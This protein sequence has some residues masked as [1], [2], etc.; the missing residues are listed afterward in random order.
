M[1]QV[2]KK[3]L[4]TIA[5]AGGMFAAAGGHAYADSGAQGHAA[6]SPGVLAGNT[7]QL[8]MDVPVQA[9]GNTVNVVGLLNP[10]AGNRCVTGAGGAH[11]HHQGG[12]QHGSAQTQGAAAGSP[13]VAAGNAVQMPVDVPV[14]ICGNSVSVVGLAN[15]AMGNTCTEDSTV[16]PSAGTDH[17]RQPSEDPTAPAPA[18]P[19]D[20]S[21]HGSVAHG[22]AAH[23]STA[24][25]P[26]AH[27]PG[28]PR[29]GQPAA[30][31]PGQGPRTPMAQPHGGHAQIGTPPG[32]QGAADGELAQTGAGPIG[33]AAPAGAALLLGGAVL[34]RRSRSARR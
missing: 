1:R 29:S 24:H 15:P 5:A 7:V 4:L 20:S 6:N 10:A 21:T 18:K 19:R 28:D 31:Y 17:P 12:G 9:C 34:Y 8:P 32:V 13:G 22:P 16:P 2:A 30:G 33:F 14:N 26:A 25:G 27:V 3:G 23:G 11:G